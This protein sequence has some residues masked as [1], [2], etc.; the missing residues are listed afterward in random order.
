[1]VPETWQSYREIAR[2]CAESRDQFFSSSQEAFR[3]GDGLKAKKDSTS[4]KYFEK[5]CIKANESAADAIFTHY[6]EKLRDNAIDLHGLF[7]TEAI[8]KLIE[9]VNKSKTKRVFELDV[10]V[11][12]GH[13]SEN[14]T[15]KIKNSVIQY[16][17]NN[18]IFHTI[19]DLNPGLIHLRLAEC[20]ELSATTKSTTKRDHQ[21]SGNLK[22]SL[23]NLGYTIIER[24]K[25]RRNS[26]ID[27]V[28]DI[29]ENK[30]NRPVAALPSTPNEQA[31]HPDSKN[32][33]KKIYN[34]KKRCNYKIAAV[35]DIIENEKNRP[36]ATIPSTP[37]EQAAHPDSKNI[38][39]KN[40]KKKKK[41]QIITSQTSNAMLSQKNNEN[42]KLP[43]TSTERAHQDSRHI[44]ETF[45]TPTRNLDCLS[46]TTEKQNVIVRYFL[47]LFF[48][49]LW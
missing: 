47:A 12:Q 48:G 13:H 5:C 3:C 32:I 43:I 33:H 19:D 40:K 45:E 9:R 14:N 11:G 8:K 30:K 42:I 27:A 29:I 1:M 37:T 2:K 26:K 20:K 18:R 44:E 10:I 6:N 49:I 16:A 31:A 7:V 28:P 35:P 38:H 23:E 4:G 25:K 17:T 22:D 46:Q 39:T 21:D 15:P 24:K 36:V 34:K 41:N